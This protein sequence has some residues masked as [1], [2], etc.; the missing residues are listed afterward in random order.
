MGL[1]PAYV[2]RELVAERLPLIFPEGTPNRNYCIRELAASTVF[3]AL[4]IGAVEGMDRYLGPVH[5]YRMTAEQAMKAANDD[6]ENY[7]AEVMKRNGH[8]VG[9]RWYADNTREPIRDETLRDGL[10]AIGAILRREDLPT[11]SGL[12][13]YAL[14][15]DFAKLFDPALFG[16]ALGDAIGHFQNVHLSKSALARVTIMRAGAASGSSGMLVTFPNG[17]TRQLA[18]GP[19]SV[20]SR[21]VIE[22]F[23][24]RFLQIPAVLW[25]S[26]SGNKVVMRDDRIATAVGLKIEVDKNLPDLILADLGP[27]DP[28]LVFVEVVATDGAI[29]SQRQDA[30]YKLTDAAGFERKQVAFLTAYHDRQSAGFKKTVAQLAW[31]SFA[32]FVSEPE[33][34]VILRNSE[35]TGTRLFELT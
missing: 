25:L 32:W 24:K 14:K 15:T 20:I 31:G 19:S 13:R 2:S 30:I 35:S 16:E 22:V 21:G 23:A 10:V 26:E 4:Y 34:V 12:P 29:T 33:H 11:T 7:A 5:V 28:L 9:T 6:R 17:E 8:V 27:A 3:V 18:P 1:F